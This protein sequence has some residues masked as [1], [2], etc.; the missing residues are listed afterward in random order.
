MTVGQLDRFG[1]LRADLFDEIR[2]RLALDG[3]C[4]S[5]EGT[6]SFVFPNYFDD[7]ETERTREAWGIRLDCYVVGPSRHYDWWGVD[8]GHALQRCE[9]DVRKWIAESVAA[10]AEELDGIL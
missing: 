8:F 2:L 10:R 4:K 3:H 5:Y 6:F 7:R 1:A 9:T